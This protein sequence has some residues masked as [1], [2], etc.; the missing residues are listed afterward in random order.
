MDYKIN[1]FLAGNSKL[2]FFFFFCSER[3]LDQFQNIESQFWLYS[4]RWGEKDQWP[5]PLGGKF[6]TLEDFLEFF[7]KFLAEEENGQPFIRMAE[8]EVPLEF[9]LKSQNLKSRFPNR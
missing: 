7:W 2:E 1:I 4:V 5:R 6:G 9:V 3:V 8:T